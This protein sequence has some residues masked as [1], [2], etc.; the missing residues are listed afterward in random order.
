MVISC[1][2]T[3]ALMPRIILNPTCIRFI[4]FVVVNIVFI[5]IIIILLLFMFI[6]Q[7]GLLQK[8]LP[9]D[10]YVISLL[11][12]EF[13]W[14][15]TPPPP[16]PPPQCFTV[17]THNPS[18]CLGEIQIQFKRGIKHKCGYLSSSRRVLQKLHL[19][20]KITTWSSQMGQLL[21]DKIIINL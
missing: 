6:L 1:G 2:P 8:E 5:I 7:L 21:R 14:Y 18:S 13:L 10:E 9:E 15:P 3:E 4:W 17:S 16:P 19:A 11:H 20:A 12:R